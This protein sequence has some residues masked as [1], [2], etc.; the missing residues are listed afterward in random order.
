MADKMMRIA[1]R[2]PNGNAKALKS[3]LNGRMGVNPLGEKF[4]M[5]F[6]TN[7]EITG[8]GTEGMVH[9]YNINKPLVIDTLTFSSNNL[10]TG[11]FLMGYSS[12]G[13][14]PETS[15]SIG[16]IRINPAL[17]IQGLFPKYIIDDGHAGI[18]IIAYNTGTN[19]YKFAIH[20]LSFPFGCR[21]SIARNEGAGTT[22]GAFLAKI[23]EY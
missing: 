4:V 18:E 7:V 13:G 12:F 17:S 23:R 22:L 1:G 8:P 21:I 20:N 3:D 11:I 19:N 15:L 2:D 5:P 10:Y 6:Q 16:D 9:V 14:V